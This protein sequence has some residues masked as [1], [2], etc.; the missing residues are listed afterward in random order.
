MVYNLSSMPSFCLSACACIP[1]YA[2]IQL[3]RLENHEVP[4]I[5]GQS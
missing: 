2:Q 3:W 4:P 5:L 1:K